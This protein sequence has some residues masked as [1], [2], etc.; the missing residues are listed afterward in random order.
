MKYLLLLAALGTVQRAVVAALPA[1]TSVSP[2]S[3]SETGAG[4]G[5]EVPESQSSVQAAAEV[6]QSLQDIGIPQAQAQ[7]VEKKVEEGLKKDTN[8]TEGV[9]NAIGDIALTAEEVVPDGDNA[10]QF[11]AV[12]AATQ[13]LL[14]GADVQGNNMNPADMNALT[15]IAAAVAI[16]EE[17]KEKVAEAVESLMETSNDGEE[18]DADNEVDTGGKSLTKRRL[19]NV[20]NICTTQ[21]CNNFVDF[22]LQMAQNQRS[23]EFM[24]ACLSAMNGLFNLGAPVAVFVVYRDKINNLPA[25]NNLN[26]LQT[27]LSQTTQTLSQQNTISQTTFDDM[28]RLIPQC[29]DTSQSLTR[30]NGRRNAG[31]GQ[32]SGRSRQQDGGIGNSNGFFRK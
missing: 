25:G 2:P 24:A 15:A 23:L 20:N 10:T 3:P 11:P 7:Q 8:S 28:N 6:S 13:S 29:I 4:T 30:F 16:S 17:S 27:L 12:M 9:A 1:E 18:A 19:R 31:F 32:R 21:R 14:N 5:T 22:S 26:Q